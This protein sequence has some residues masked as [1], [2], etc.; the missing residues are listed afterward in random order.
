[1]AGKRAQASAA[2]T[3]ALSYF[4]T[5]LALLLDDCW[6]RRHDLIFA[7]ELARAQ[8]EFVCGAVTQAQDHLH[9]LST[10][11]ATT[12]EKTTVACLRVDLYMSMDRSEDAVTIGLEIGSNLWASTGPRARRK[13]KHCANMRAS[14]PGLEVEKSKISSTPR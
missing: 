10:R 3:S 6:Q 8:C 2:C 13:K 14:G 1:M 12:V 4:T 9:V 5:G 11:A 7:L